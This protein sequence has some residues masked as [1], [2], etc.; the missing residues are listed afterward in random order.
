MC[1]IS[2]RRS[3]LLL[4]RTCSRRCRR[5]KR[6]RRCRRCMRGSAGGAG[7]WCILPFTPHRARPEEAATLCTRGSNPMHSGCAS[8]RPPRRGCS[9]P[10]VPRPPRLAAACTP[11]PHTRGAA[12]PARP[13]GPAHSARPAD[14]VGLAVAAA[15][16][17]PPKVLPRRG[18]RAVASSAAVS[19]CGRGRT[20][21]R[22][23][24]PLASVAGSAQQESARAA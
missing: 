22:T 10:M 11:R 21:G 2:A 5:C 15:A 16:V 12:D 17:A 7:R 9:W 23:H 3:G 24:A 13:A 6:R 18:W 4:K 8:P 19:P 14:P 20:R 1:R